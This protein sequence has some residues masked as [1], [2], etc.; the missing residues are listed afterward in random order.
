MNLV[1]P[2]SRPLI[3]ERKQQIQSP[4]TDLRYEFTAQ[5]KEGREIEVEVSVSH[6]A[7]RDGIAT[8]G[9]LRDIT[10]R[11]RAEEALQQSEARLR[12]V[13]QNMPVMMD[14]FD[15]QGN[16]LIWNQECERV[17][18]FS[19]SEI[20][21]NPKAIQLLYPNENYR[22]FAIEQLAKYGGNFRN[23]EWNINCKNGSTRSI[24][25]SNMSEEF[26]IPGWYSWAIGLDITERVQAEQ[27]LRESNHRLE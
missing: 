22:T 14:A 19:A 20:V 13:L 21:G 25:W 16:I 17:T 9:I 4:N 26:P 8:Q 10:E 1:A 24:L 6:I 15:A 18:G 23:M 12:L 5:N 27:A 7:Y 2:K 3:A 11:K